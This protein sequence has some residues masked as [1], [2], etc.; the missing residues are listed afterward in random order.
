[1]KKKLERYYTHR[2]HT[3]DELDKPQS[4]VGCVRAVGVRDHLRIISP[5]SNETILDVGCGIGRFLKPFS[6]SKVFG[7]DMNEEMLERG[8]DLGV[9]LVRCDAEYLPF[10][11]RTF[12]IAHSAGLLG[13]FRSKRI[14]EEMARVTKSKRKIFISFPAAESFSGFAVS[15]FR[16]L[17]Y[18][19]SLLDFWYTKDGIVEMF[20][21]NV[22]V[23]KIYRLGWEPPFQ[24][25]LRKLESGSLSRLFL[26]LESRLRDKPLFKYFGGRFLVEAVK[27]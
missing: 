16:R 21:E 12:D 23:S 26:F 15:L 27:S 20:P 6:S 24:R 4:I 18:N 1:M 22:K 3:Y 11:D 14:V 2:A 17:K 13:V 8:K 19:P 10:K 7:V 9:P 5:K 25:L